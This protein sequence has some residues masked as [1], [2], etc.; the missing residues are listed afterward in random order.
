MIHAL[1]FAISVLALI[2]ASI[3]IAVVLACIC[4]FVGVYRECWRQQDEQNTNK[5]RN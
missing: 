1:I 4:I 5:R 3:V 2:G